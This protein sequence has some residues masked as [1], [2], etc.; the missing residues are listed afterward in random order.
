MT[1]DRPVTRLM[2]AELKGT[3]PLLLVKLGYRIFINSL[4]GISGIIDSTV[5]K[6]ITIW[7]RKK[8]MKETMM[9]VLIHLA[10]P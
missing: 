7:T 3:F 5:K 10:I 9:L 8:C 6:I 4:H 1:T 2:M